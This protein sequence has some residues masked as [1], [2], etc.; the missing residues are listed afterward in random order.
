VILPPFDIPHS[1]HT[2]SRFNASWHH[3][4][5]IA[6]QNLSE[7][8]DTAASKFLVRAGKVIVILKKVEE[9]AWT[10]LRKK[11]DS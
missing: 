11:S 8:I 1:L 3:V 10:D 4:F 6:F 9:K 2:L 5:F 7:E